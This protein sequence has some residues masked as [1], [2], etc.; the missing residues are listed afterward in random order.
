MKKNKAKNKDIFIKLKHNSL[1]SKIVDLFK[2]KVPKNSST[3]EEI[4]EILKA[5]ENIKL[6]GLLINIF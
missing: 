5:K 4:D 2:L 1:A 3:K 6:L